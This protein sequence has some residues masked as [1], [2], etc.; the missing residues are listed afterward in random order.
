MVYLNCYK[1]LEEMDRIRANKIS[2]KMLSIDRVSKKR[3]DPYVYQYRTLDNFWAIIESDSFW[4]TNA[5][6]SNDQEEQHLG[7]EKLRE[8]LGDNIKENQSLGDFYIVCFCDENDKLSQWRGY[9]AEGVSIGFDFNNIRPFYIKEKNEDK[10]RRVYNSCYK[11]Q[12]INE[13]TSKD[14]FAD[15]FDLNLSDNENNYENIRRQ[16]ADIIAYVK[17]DGFYEEAESRLVFSERDTDLS[18]CIQY[19]NVGNIKVPYIVVKAGDIEKRKCSKCMIRLNFESTMAKELEKNLSKCI[20]KMRNVEVVNCTDTGKGS[21]DDRK[22][23]GCTLRE[24]YIPGVNRQNP[25]CRY[26]C[27]GPEE[28]H[29]ENRNEIYISD[30]KNQEDVYNEVQSFLVNRGEELKN[31]KIWCE[32]HLPI[33]KITVGNLRNKEIVAESIRHYCKQHYWL[34]SVDVNYSCTP[35]RSSLI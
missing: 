13:H 27:S 24:P 28:F 35:F 25:V 19:R 29:I 5:R 9:A 3:S 11:V 32:G 18:D 31:V 12:Y 23:F 20:S 33:R 8:V 17:H 10:Y 30:S 1:E 21:T 2:V 34:R 15:K 22:C 26:A 7:M 14:I 6:F 16:A 4:A